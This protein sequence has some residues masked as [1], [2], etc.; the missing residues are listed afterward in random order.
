MIDG[1]KKCLAITEVIIHVLIVIIQDIY[2]HING[3]IVSQ[4][5]AD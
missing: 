3:R 5:V 2:S 4:Y 1:E